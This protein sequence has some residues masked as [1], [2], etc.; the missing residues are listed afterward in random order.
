[1][2][3]DL[4]RPQISSTKQL[5]ELANDYYLHFPTNM[6]VSAFFLRKFYIL[7]EE[8]TY[9]QFKNAVF[10]NMTDYCAWMHDP[11]KLE[12][13]VIIDGKEIAE[14]RETIQEYEDPDGIIKPSKI[15]LDLIVFFTLSSSYKLI[16]IQKYLERVKITW[17][18]HL[19]KLRN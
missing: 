16:F 7:L 8:K 6:R 2:E 17:T 4:F 5:W 13:F 1:M 3:F 11:E 18:L 10:Q 9:W 15:F 12:D 14:A 19:L